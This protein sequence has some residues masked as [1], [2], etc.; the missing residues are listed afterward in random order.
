VGDVR[1]ALALPF[2]AARLRRQLAAVDS[3]LAAAV[4][5]RESRLIA[6]AR[7][8]VGAG[9]G[10]PMVDIARRQLLELEDARSRCAGETAGAQQQATALE[11]G[12]AEAFAAYVA[13]D[14]QLDAEIVRLTEELGPVARDMA[15]L[16]RQFDENDATSAALARRIGADERKIVRG[17]LSAEDA[18]AVEAGLASL[19]A[20]R[21]AVLRERPALAARLAELEPAIAQL[22]EALDH[23]RRQRES[24]RAAKADAVAATEQQLG[25][26]RA[27][28][29]R[30][31]AHLDQ[32]EREIEAVMV[33]L[34][35]CLVR[36]RPPFM[37]QR[38]GGPDDSDRLIADLQ[39]RRDAVQA[40][41]RAVDAWAAARGATWM[42]LALAGLS[43]VSW[44]LIAG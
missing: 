13:A 4:E 8:A 10:H 6:V 41:L 35:E 26:L 24:T 11:R 30:A 33:G 16:R 14:E 12:L 5:H 39:R 27:R 19:R 1:Y 22:N 7:F 37:A 34:A 20:E 36:E 23:K 21:D 9:G 25:E 32:T 29:D 44:L 42:V 43:G 18:I 2:A 28:L 38:L 40:E 15:A 17:T 31:R 3:D